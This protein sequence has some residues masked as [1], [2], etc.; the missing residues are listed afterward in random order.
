MNKDSKY[1]VSPCSRVVNILLSIVY[2]LYD[3]T[4]RLN[5]KKETIFSLPLPSQYLF[6]YTHF[7]E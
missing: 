1:S 3:F 7:N 2:C 6:T 5:L 4:S